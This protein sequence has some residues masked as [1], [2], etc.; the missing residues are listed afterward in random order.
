[1]GVGRGDQKEAGPGRKEEAKQSPFDFLF[2]SS[3]KDLAPDSALGKVLRPWGQAGD[4]YLV[5][6]HGVWE[7]CVAL[8][9]REVTL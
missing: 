8:D 1:M 9:D 7:E 4:P 6:S 3:P 5:E 2:I